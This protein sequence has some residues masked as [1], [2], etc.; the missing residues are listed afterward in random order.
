MPVTGTTTG[1]SSAVI[2]EPKVIL[3]GV[4]SVVKE[5]AAQVASSPVTSNALNSVSVEVSEK[6]TTASVA[7]TA[8]TVT[9]KLELRV[10]WLFP[11]QRVP[12]VWGKAVVV[13]NRLPS[14]V[15]PESSIQKTMIILPEIDIDG[16]KLSASVVSK[17]CTADQ[18]LPSV[19]R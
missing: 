11:V 14:T 16:L 19:E 13:S 10:P 17:S 7:D 8:A 15:S 18:V 4:R 12:R 1:L 9:I 5:P 3:P 6:A 2:P